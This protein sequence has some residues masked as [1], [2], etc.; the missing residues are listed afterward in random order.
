MAS[1]V[2]TGWVEGCYTIRAIKTIREKAGIPLN[3]ALAIVNRV[4]RNETVV[5]Q[6]ASSGTAQE[7]AEA[8]VATGLI[9]NVA[10][11]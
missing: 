4:I 8:L 9:A 3:E 6:V 11:I 1:V 10:L 2:I 5:V 7:L